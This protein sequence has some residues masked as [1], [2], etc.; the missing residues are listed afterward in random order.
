[1]TFSRSL[2]LKPDEKLQIHKNPV[3]QTCKLESDHSHH[4]R[5]FL[6]YKRIRPSIS[7]TTGQLAFYNTHSPRCSKIHYE[8]LA[9]LS[10]LL[11]N[12]F[13]M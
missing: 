5:D 2:L 6:L 1:M 10:S 3:L 7:L 9:V 13:V 8:I 11:V 4:R 12:P